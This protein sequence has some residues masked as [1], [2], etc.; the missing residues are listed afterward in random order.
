M[1]DRKVGGAGGRGGGEVQKEQDVSPMSV[2]PWRI[3][4][5]YISPTILAWLKGRGAFNND[6][7]T[8]PTAI[9][10]ALKDNTEI[11]FDNISPLHVSSRKLADPEES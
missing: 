1:A 8:K 5:D 10:Y 11:L 3:D 9:S 6:Q 2:S 7:R 4:D